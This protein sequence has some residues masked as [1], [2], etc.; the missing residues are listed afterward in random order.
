MSTI[1]KF[2][3]QIQFFVD[4]KEVYRHSELENVPTETLIKIFLLR[5]DIMFVRLLGLQGNE[6]KKIKQGSFMRD[7]IACFYTSG[8]LHAW[9]SVLQ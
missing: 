2:P 1:Q 4:P 6:E 5:N 7:L 8:A 9:E 3:A